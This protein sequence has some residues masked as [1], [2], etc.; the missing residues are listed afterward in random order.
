MEP[1]LVRMIG[2]PNV[3]FCPSLSRA[4]HPNLKFVSFLSALR[5][6]FRFKGVTSKYKFLVRFSDLKYA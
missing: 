3:P 4:S 2:D 5:T 6:N 1:P